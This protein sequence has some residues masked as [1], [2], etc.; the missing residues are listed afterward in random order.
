MNDLL[1]A[2]KADSQDT[3]VYSDF[4]QSLQKTPPSLCQDIVVIRLEREPTLPRCSNLLVAEASLVLRDVCLLVPAALLRGI[5][6]ELSVAWSISVL[7]NGK[8]K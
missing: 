5:D 1:L 7:Y 2:S 4:R 6:E 3:G 8:R